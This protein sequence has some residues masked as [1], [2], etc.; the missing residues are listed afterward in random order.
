M[1][2]KTRFIPVRDEKLIMNEI[3]LPKKVTDVIKQ[4]SV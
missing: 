4:G 2:C 1:T 3:S